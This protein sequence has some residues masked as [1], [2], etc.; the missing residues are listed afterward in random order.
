MA[1][2]CPLVNE[3]RKNLEKTSPR[4][5]IV[6]LLPVGLEHS[7]ELGQSAPVSKVCPKKWPKDLSQRFRQE[8]HDATCWPRK[9][10]K[11]GQR[12]LVRK[13]NLGNVA[14]A[15]STELSPPNVWHF[16]CRLRKLKFFRLMY[17]L[18]LLHSSECFVFLLAWIHTR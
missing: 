5:G 7:K 11:T 8:Q 3:T 2:A 17:R 6:R 10:R 13:A 14:C 1:K 15:R 4:C 12:V 16:A 9:L 18:I